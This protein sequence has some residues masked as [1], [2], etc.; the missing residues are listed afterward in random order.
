MRVTVIPDVGD[1]SLHL[2][3]S[4]SMSISATGYFFANNLRTKQGVVSQNDSQCNVLVAS[5]MMSFT[6]LLAEQSPPPH[7]PKIINTH[8]DRS[9]ND[10][11][12]LTSCITY[13]LKTI[14]NFLQMRQL[15]KIKGCNS[16][17]DTK[18]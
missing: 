11:I 9:I 16:Y 17:E 1:E 6:Q 8:H 12:N 18:T 5:A 3:R 13:I 15:H 4:L 14:K 7:P 10:N 2:I